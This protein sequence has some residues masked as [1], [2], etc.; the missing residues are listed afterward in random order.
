[1][2]QYISGQARSISLS[3]REIASTINENLSNLTPQRLQDITNDTVDTINQ[4]EAMLRHNN[5]RVRHHARLGI[6]ALPQD[7]KIRILLER[8]E[9][10][11]HVLCLLADAIAGGQGPA[12]AQEETQAI[13]NGA[14]N[15]NQ[16]MNYLFATFT[17]PTS[18]AETE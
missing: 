18:G 9:N 15:L 2:A 3:R 12:V 14:Q 6:P 10:S 5:V 13:T 1:M 11:V 16:L 7:P 4:I 17:P 8:L